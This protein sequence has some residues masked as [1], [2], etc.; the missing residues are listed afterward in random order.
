MKTKILLFLVPVI[1]LITSCNSSLLDKTGAA[2][3]NT[4][5]IEVAEYSNKTNEAIER[6]DETTK[7]LLILYKQLA[8]EAKTA[9]A[10]TREANKEQ[11]ESPITKFI[12]LELGLG[13]VRLANIPENEKEKILALERF[14]L[15]KAGESDKWKQA[16]DSSISQANT[17]TTNLRDTLKLADQYKTERDEA[18]AK[19]VKAQE[20]YKKLA[21]KKDKEYKDKINKMNDAETKKQ[22]WILRIIGI[23]CVI[24]FGLTAYYGGKPAFLSISAPLG[25]LGCVCLGLAQIIAQWWFKYAVGGVCLIILG[26]CVYALI[27]YIKEK[28]AY[29]NIKEISKAV[30]PVLDELYENST[31]EEKKLLDEKIFSKLS[32]KMNQDTKDMIHLV[33]ANKV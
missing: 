32:S 20:E 33:R 7:N 22:V 31:D 16:Y 11:P 24:A 13:Q 2:S 12:D 6:L 1:F 26:L 8:S 28:Q 21:E 30:V 19:E 29:N 14:A 15:I 25:V 23:I 4:K 18:R 5:Q 3:K 9:I 17:M 10:V 27:K